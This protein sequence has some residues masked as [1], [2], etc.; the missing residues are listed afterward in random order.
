MSQAHEMGATVS[1]KAKSSA[2]RSR[3]YRKRK[4][5]NPSPA[6]AKTDAQR[7][8]EYRERKKMSSHR[9]RHRLKL[10]ELENI[11]S[12]PSI[13][14]SEIPTKKIYTNQEDLIED[15][16]SH[17][18]NTISNLDMLLESKSANDEL[19]TYSNYDE[20]CNGHIDFFTNFKNNS[21]GHSCAVCDRLWWQK[22]LKATSSIH[23]NILQIIV[24]NY[25]VGSTVQVCSSC[26]TVLDKQKIPTLSTFNGFS[27]PIIPSHLPT[28]DF[29]SQRLIS[30]R[31]P[32]MQI[33]RLRHVHEQNDICGQ[34][35]NVP[36]LVNTMVH[37]LP[38]HMDDDHCLYVNIEKKLIHKTSHVDGLV[39]KRK[40][41]EWLTYLIETPLYIHHNITIDDAVFNIDDD[42]D[43]E[44]NVDDISERVPV[45]ESLTSQ[46]QSL[47]WN[48]D[49]MLLM[50]GGTSRANNTPF[51]MFDEYAEELS[52][53][54]IYGGHF[55]QYTAEIHVTS[56]MQANSEIRRSDRRGAEPQHLL[57]VAMKIIRERVKDHYIHVLKNF[58]KEHCIETILPS[59]RCIP[60]SASYW[61]D[62][63][64]YLFAI[65]RQKG[66]PTA[67]MTLTANETGW[68]D[69]LQLLYRL[70]NNGADISDELLTD[71]SYMHKA[72]LVNEDAVTCAIYFSKLLHCLLHTLQAKKRSPFGRYRVLDYFRR[73]EFQDR[74]SPQA[75]IFLWLDNAPNNLLSN[76]ADAIKIIDQLVSVSASE[77]SGNIKFQT[78]KHT[79]TCYKK[80]DSFNKP[81]CRFGTPFMPSRQTVTL[82]PMKDTDDDYCVENL[83]KYK[84]HY[85]Y[86]QSNLENIDYTDFNHFYSHNNIE[87]DLHYNNILRAG[88][89]RPK[90]FYKRTPS[91][92]WHNPFNPFIL[93]HLQSNMNFQIIEDE[94]ACAAYIVEYIIKANRN[95]S[96]LQR[97]II[98]IIDENPEFDITQITRELSG[99]VLNSVE[100]SAQEA[101]WYLL[102]EPMAKSSIVTVYIPTIHPIERQRISKSMKEFNDMDEDY[103]DIWKENWFDAYETR[104]EHLNDVTLAQFASKYCKNHKGDYSE[105]KEARVI[106]YRNYDM[107]ENFDDYRREMVLLHIPFRSEDNDV[108]AGNKYVQLYE[109]NKDT[110]LQRRKEFECLDVAETLE[111]CRQLCRDVENDDVEIQNE[112]NPS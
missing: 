34:I 64:K 60:N 3:E 92:I 71:M 101:A 69:L 58:T 80:N 40:I 1:S 74:G 56:L 11:S 15:N 85:N 81:N 18:G 90:L 4:R 16:N 24:P 50:A 65:M 67:F 2:E 87:S 26:K 45:E 20:H 27:Y 95:I 51:T 70:K 53:P 109:D 48:D 7:S 82:L 112:A 79:F 98:E 99:D 96:N 107:V 14:D 61:A 104:P 10:K 66:A 75:H 93:H 111:I 55:R 35:I 29:V 59:L 68:M 83:I 62:R 94:H 25:I 52:F 108:L 30:P 103:T 39:N 31:I 57:Y 6:N 47:M 110:I 105:R 8:K 44:S 5:L 21:F 12:N 28:L 86:V 97:Q 19:P 13:S 23:D 49:Q 76:D 102:R 43:T 91:E 63:K 89:N 36:L 37:Q 77:A 9:F 33:R 41:K 106:R 54:T 17:E 72:K 22:D 46:Q 73:I 38:R 84:D 42:N 100:M 78:H 88:I 32:F